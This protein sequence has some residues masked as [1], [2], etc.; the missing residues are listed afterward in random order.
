[1]CSVWTGVSIVDPTAGVY[2]LAVAERR[3]RVPRGKG[4]VVSSLYK[5]Y[6]V[7]DG[8]TERLPADR[9]EEG[10]VMQDVVRKVV[11]V[12]RL[13]DLLSKL[14]LHVCTLCQKLEDVRHRARCR[15]RR[16]E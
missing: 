8:Q 2:S 12:A 11:A 15:F 9:V 7:E 14:L 3:G 1:M 4:S 16:R 13:G 5:T 6:I 10:Q